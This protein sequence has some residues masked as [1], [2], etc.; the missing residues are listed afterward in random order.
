MSKQALLTEYY[1]ARWR[2]HTAP[3]GTKRGWYRE[4]VR[5]T[6]DCMNAGVPV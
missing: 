2:Y 1:T 5:A 4:F 6:K 3:K